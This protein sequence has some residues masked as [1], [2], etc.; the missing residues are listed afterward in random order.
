M[1]KLLSSGSDPLPFQFWHRYAALT[2][3][4]TFVDVDY[5]QLM[6]RKRDTMLSNGLLRDALLKTRLR[7]SEQP[8]YLRS[9]KYMALGCDL[10]DLVTLERLLRAEFDVPASSIMFVAEVS[11]TYMPLKDSDALIQWAS[12]IEDGSP[13][14][15]ILL[16]VIC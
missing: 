6:E 5:P 11:V 8:V 7:E 12:T 15:Q 1:E 2:Q 16:I 13:T 3:S 9:D 14:P 10:K 4:S